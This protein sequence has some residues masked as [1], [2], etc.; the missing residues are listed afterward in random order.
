M[1]IKQLF[2]SLAIATGIILTGCSTA[3]KHPGVIGSGVAGP[4][5]STSGMAYDSGY[6]GAGGGGSICR[7]A[8]SNQSYYFDLDSFAV[9]SEDLSCIKGQA[10]YLISHPGSKVRV[11]GNC[12]NRGSREYNRALGWKRANAVRSVL[13]QEGVAPSQIMTFSWGSE[14]ASQGTGEAVWSKDRRVDMIFRN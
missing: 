14:R 8:P 4:D 3:H 11:E 10:R 9:H 13:L 6:G 5:V 1:R 2:F 12:D 7:P